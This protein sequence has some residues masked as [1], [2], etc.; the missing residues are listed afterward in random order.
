MKRMMLVLTTL[1]IVMIS[2][3]GAQTPI[4]AV[5]A[6][7]GN[8]SPVV[9]LQ[10]LNPMLFSDPGMKNEPIIWLQTKNNTPVG[11]A[12]IKGGS[13]IIYQNISDYIGLTQSAVAW[14]DAVIAP[15]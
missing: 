7:Q 3:S 5:R 1:I 2:V 11:Y 8:I 15:I 12:L 9:N 14:K 6:N 4:D 13:H 10:H